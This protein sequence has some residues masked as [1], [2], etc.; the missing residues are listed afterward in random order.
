[1]GEIESKCLDAFPE[2]LKSLAA[3]AR[4]LASVL[5]AEE[6]PLA[7][8]QHLAGALNYLFKSLDLVPDGIEDLGFLDDAFILRVA[9]AHARAAGGD[10]LGD[11]GATLERLGSDT[12]LIR[13]FLG[14]DYA[15]LERYEAG[16]SQTTARGRSVE[17]IVQ[18]AEVRNELVRDVA[19]WA[20]S[21]GP[22]TFLRDEKSLVRL[23]AFLGTRLPQ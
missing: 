14:S 6:L 18:D 15:R 4:E 7:A 10:E 8:R 9:A 5:G 12:A 11:R 2:W 22:P 3:D 23:R 13:D 19:A 16:L 21:Y 1:M 17:A 20:E